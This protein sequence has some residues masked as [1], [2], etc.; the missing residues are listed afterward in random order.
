MRVISVN[1]GRPRL[2][3]HRGKTFN[4]AIGKEPIVGP[5]RVTA[6]GLA[7][8]HQAN[9]ELHGGTELALCVYPHDHYAYLGRRLGHELAVPSF[10]ENLTTEGLLESEACIGDVYRIGGEVRV[11]ISQPRE[12]C[13]T[14][15]RKHDCPA[16]AQWI[17]ETGYTGFYLRVLQPGDV[18]AGDTIERV[19]RPHPGL[20]V[21][22][23]MRAMFDDP[24]PS[25]LVRRFAECEGLSP[26]W[27]KR[28]GKRLN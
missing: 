25:E 7:L 15:T 16:M 4:S 23:A 20:T 14:L 2:M 24:V 6:T 13:S 18:R 26:K 17:H 28:M 9:R 27:R 21:A 3:E 10:G 22:Q 19:E 1:A 12:P 11:Q 5:A 8:D